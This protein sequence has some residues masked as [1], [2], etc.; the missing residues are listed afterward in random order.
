VKFQNQN[1]TAN[2]AAAS[3]SRKRAADDDDEVGPVARVTYWTLNYRRFAVELRDM[4][5]VEFVKSTIDEVRYS[6]K[7]TQIYARSRARS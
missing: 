3:G 7:F 6:C 1:K 2:L 5:I 4:M